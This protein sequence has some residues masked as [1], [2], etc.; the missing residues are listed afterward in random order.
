MSILLR[1]I[2][3]FSLFVWGFFW[4][5]LIESFLIFLQYFWPLGS[6]SFTLLLFW[7]WLRVTLTLFEVFFTVENIEC[8]YCCDKSVWPG[9][10][11]GITLLTAFFSLCCL[12]YWESFFA[13]CQHH[14]KFLVIAVE[15]LWLYFGDDWGVLFLFWLLVNVEVEMFAKRELWVHGWCWFSW[16][17]MF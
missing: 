11:I 6:L 1:W 9:K 14:V 3:I 10:F 4:K 2:W 15:L 17:M 7:F 13:L 5:I 8:F 16:K 12:R